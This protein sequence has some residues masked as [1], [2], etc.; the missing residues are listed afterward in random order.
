MRFE[1]T[2]PKH[3]EVRRRR[4]FAFLPVRIHNEIRWLEMVTVEQMYWECEWEN[5]KFID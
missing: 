2:Y 4:F 3:K 1:I 5:C